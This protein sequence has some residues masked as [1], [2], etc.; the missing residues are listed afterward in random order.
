[1]TNALVKTGRLVTVFG[2]SGFI[3]RHVV[4]ALARDGWRVRVAARRPDLAF[5]LQ[6][7]GQVGQIHAVQANLRYPQSLA[8]ALRNAD[9]VVN[10]VGIMNPIGKQQFSSIQ[11]EGARALATATRE[12]GIHNFVHI[13][14][15]GANPNSSSVYARTKA[16][17]EAAIHEIL[18]EGIIFR[19]SIVFG[20]ED[21]FFNRFAAMARVSPALPLIGGGKTKL[22]PVFVGD[23]AKAVTAALG[24]AAKAGTTYELG[25]PEIRSLRQIL[26]FI[27]ATTERQRLLV[28][29]PFP[30][31]KLLALGTELAES[32]SFGLF[33]SV[34]SLTRDQV[35]LLRY[36]NVVSE[37]AKNEGRSLAA[38]GIVPESFETLA[39]PYLYRFRKAGQFT[40]QSRMA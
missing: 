19:P 16:Q 27:L 26:E 2:G 28:P 17:G 9:A 6:P 32:L 22:Q 40:D 29:L 20:P 37:L 24:G 25:G 15:I 34:F 8:L 30:I 35:E 33:P 11:A 18:P 1:M 12:A 13:S 3:G 5:H 36:D 23:V 7:A 10:L 38:F 14:A 39:P 21:N 4:R 31:A